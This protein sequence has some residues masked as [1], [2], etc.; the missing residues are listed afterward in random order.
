MLGISHPK[1]GI[2][3]VK[4]SAKRIIRTVETNTPDQIFI[5][6]KL[7]SNALLTFHMEGGEPFPGEPGLRWH[8]VGDEGELMITNNIMMMDVLHTGAKILLL[9]Y[10]Q[11][12]A[13]D[14]GDFLNDIPHGQ[15]TMIPVEIEPLQD[16]MT[17]LGG[18][19]QNVG[20]LYEAF[21]DERIEDYADWTVG[22]RRHELMEEMFQRWDGKAPFAY[23]TENKF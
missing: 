6:G 14:K 5:Q 15:Q 7:L 23:T 21:A 12:A 3:D 17:E 1:V 20:R 4:D 13:S 10:C 18:V 19:A 9:E 22:L 16:A 11:R 8:I 2:F